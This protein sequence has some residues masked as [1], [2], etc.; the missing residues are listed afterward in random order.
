MEIMND[1]WE[2]L[3]RYQG[4]NVDELQYK[5]ILYG[6]FPT[7]RNSPLKAGFDRIL[8]VGDAS[9]IQSPLSFGGFG[10][11]C[12]HI[13]RIVGAVDEALA[14]LDDPMQDLYPT[15]EYVPEDF[16]S[17]VELGMINCYQPNLST[18]WMF[19]RAMSVRIG[20]QP[21]NKVIVGTLSNSFSGNLHVHMMKYML[22]HLSTIVFIRYSECE[23]V[24]VS[25][26][27]L[28]FKLWKS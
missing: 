6:C 12:R 22:T 24:I 5:R 26:V 13:E 9:G 17:A 15:R 10:S 18:C 19:Q 23:F 25:Y 11:L 8:Q 21:N 7:Y 4:V 1:Y 2:L 3:P 28:Y 16:V 20:N 27:L 14:P